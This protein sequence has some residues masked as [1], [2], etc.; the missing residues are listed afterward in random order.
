MRR[1]RSWESRHEGVSAI[2]Y[3]AFIILIGILAYRGAVR[4]NQ[5]LE[6]YPYTGER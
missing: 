1:I 4:E 2:L 6:S 3:L 5:L